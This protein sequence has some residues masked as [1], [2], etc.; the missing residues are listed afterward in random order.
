MVLSLKASAGNIDKYICVCM[1]EM[2]SIDKYIFTINNFYSR[3]KSRRL[4]K[5]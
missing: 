4:W 5:P 2:K 1:S 3:H